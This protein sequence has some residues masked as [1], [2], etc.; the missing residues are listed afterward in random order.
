MGESNPILLEDRTPDAFGRELATIDVLSL[1]VAPIVAFVFVVV[2]S[3]F[4]S[5]PNRTLGSFRGGLASLLD[6]S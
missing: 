2:V 3:N 1:S 4:L 5:L 6:D